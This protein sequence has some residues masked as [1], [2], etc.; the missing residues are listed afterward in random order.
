MG[1]LD[2]KTNVESTRKTPSTWSL[3]MHAQE[4][5]HRRK[6]TRKEGQMEGEWERIGGDGRGREGSEGRGNRFRGQG[7]SYSPANHKRNRLSGITKPLKFIP[8]MPFL[9]VCLEV[10]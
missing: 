8:K 5:T 4:I 9:V 1:E 2:S 3:H 10:E 7:F 6:E